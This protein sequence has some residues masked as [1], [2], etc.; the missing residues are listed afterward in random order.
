MGLSLHLKMKPEATTE[1]DTV[2]M[3]VKLQYQY[4]I[5]C[6]HDPTLVTVLKKPQD[7]AL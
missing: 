5:Q 3:G 4:D 6:A 7:A 2:D 1:V